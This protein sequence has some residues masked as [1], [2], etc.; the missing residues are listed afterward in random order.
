ML[1]SGGAALLTNQASQGIDGTLMWSGFDRSAFRVIGYG[2]FSADVQRKLV[3]A[4]QFE[5]PHHFIKGVTLGRSRGIEDPCAP[6]APVT[7]KTAF[8]DPN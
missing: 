2:V 5:V 7:P 8:L 3:V 6:R 1:E 4:L